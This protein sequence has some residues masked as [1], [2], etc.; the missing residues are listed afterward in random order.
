MKKLFSLIAVVALVGNALADSWFTTNNLAA[1][2]HYLFAGPKVVT[3]ITITTTNDTPTIIALYDGAITNVVA[4]YT[5]YTTYASNVV[6]EVIT[7]TGVTNSYTTSRLFVA[8]VSNAAATNNTPVKIAGTVDKLNPLIITPTLGA[9]Y[10]LSRFTLS[11]N[12]AGV[13]ALVGYRSP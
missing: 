6:E 9:Q 7:P 5:S 13:S 12:A 8:P 3:S 2:T 11:N 10:F 1:N 4:A